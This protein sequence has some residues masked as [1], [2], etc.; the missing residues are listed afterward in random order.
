M[1]S[2]TIKDKSFVP[3]I[4]EK[5]LQEAVKKIAEEINKNLKRKSLCF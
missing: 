1:S 4:E 2:I 3:F 5:K